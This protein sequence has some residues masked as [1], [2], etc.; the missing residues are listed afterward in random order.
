M[1]AAIPLRP[2]E[3]ITFDRDRL[4][5]VC[6]EKGIDA[7]IF[8]MDILSEIETLVEIAR[9]QV[10]DREGLVRTCSRL[11]RR[12]EV[13]G[14]VTLEEVA[15]SVIRCLGE[16]NEYGMRACHARLVRLGRPGAVAEWSFAGAMQPDG[17][18]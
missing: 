7:E 14:M 5:R 18:A 8:L 1:P 6:D 13:I 17:A 12:A 16:G 9:G 3:H 4:F 11:I 2:T 10:D 15:R